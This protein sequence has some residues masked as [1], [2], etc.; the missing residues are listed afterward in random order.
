MLIKFLRKIGL[1]YL[2]QDCLIYMSASLL[3]QYTHL[4]RKGKIKS[5]AKIAQ[6][7]AEE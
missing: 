5:L 2:R 1:G 6:L 3:N 4:V 7:S